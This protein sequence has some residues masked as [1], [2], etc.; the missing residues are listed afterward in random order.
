MNDRLHKQMESAASVAQS[1]WRNVVLPNLQPVSG[2]ARQQLEQP[3]QFRMHTVSGQFLSMKVGQQESDWAINFKKAIVV[4]FQTKSVNVLGNNQ[5]QQQQFNGIVAD[6]SQ[7]Q[8]NQ[9]AYWTT[10][11]EGLD[12]ICSVDYQINELSNGQAEQMQHYFSEDC[13][14][15]NNLKKF[16]VTKTR[17]VDSCTKRNVFGFYKPGFF[18]CPNSRAKAGSCEGQWTRTSMT[19]YYT[20]GQSYQQMQIQSVLNEGEL[21]QDLFGEK[22]ERFVTG[23]Q[24]RLVLISK[25]QINQHM[26]VA[27]SGVKNINSL[28]YG[29]EQ[30][31]SGIESIYS[32]I[33]EQMKSQRQH[34][35][36]SLLSIGHQQQQ[37]SYQEQRQQLSNGHIQKMIQEVVQTVEQ[38]VDQDLVQPQNRA[39]KEITMKALNLARALYLFEQEELNQV[40]NQLKS[41]YQSQPQQMTTMKNVFF[42]T[43]IM[44]GSQN[45]VLF[46]KQKVQS[47]QVETQQLMNFFVFMPHYIITPTELVLENIFDLIKSD[48]IMRE[49]QVIY[50]QA[51]LSFSALVQRACL[52]QT[53]ESSYPVELYGQFCSPKHQIVEAKWIP[54]LQQQVVAGQA[55]VEEKPEWLNLHL[56]ALS[57]LRHPAV[58]PTILNVLDMKQHQGQETQLPQALQMTR[59]IAVYALSNAGQAQPQTTIQ[60]LATILKNQG[61]RTEIRIAAFNSLLKM[62]PELYVLQSIAAM[63]WRESNKDVIDVINSGFFFLAHQ[64]DLPIFE[65]YGSSIQRKAALILPLLKWSR[66]LNQATLYLGDKLSMLDVSY[67]SIRSWRYDGTPS[68]IIPNNYYSRLTY[69][70]NRYQF[71]VSETFFKLN[72]YDNLIQQLTEVLIPGTQH[73]TKS[74]VGE[75]ILN[76]LNSEWK[77]VIKNLNIERRDQPQSSQGALFMNFFEDF[78]MFAS[79]QSTSSQMLREKLNSLIGGSPKASNMCGQ[80]NLNIQRFMDLSPAEYSIPSELGLPILIEVHMPVTLSLKGQI[81]VQCGQEKIVPDFTMDVRTLAIGQYVGYVGTVCPFTNEM[82]LTGVDQHTV[83]DLPFKTNVRFDHQQQ[84]VSVAASLSQEAQTNEFDVIHFHVRPYTVR[85]GLYSLMPF[86]QLPQTQFKK[87]QS[88]TQP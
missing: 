60:A 82:L 83:L 84:Q 56:V 86:S 8:Q 44:A 19:K 17:N 32:N 38:L 28:V 69:L 25:R 40:Y 31:K 51:I 46:L 47:Q 29:V 72:G 30:K 61:E 41:K 52:S 2:E 76:G 85:A 63:T 73:K 36:R 42:D 68:M 53:R 49:N 5:E 33:Q 7:Q 67:S 9:M 20:C 16:V 34:E 75:K 11:E 24:Q 14:E 64:R 22:T 10:T 70:L 78:P 77:Q 48:Y 62:N 27:S 58:I 1:N 21:E 65:Q 54:F 50:N 12:G 80:H 55:Q 18:R 71:V 87:I 88:P 15:N 74:Q 43:V 26:Q 66:N 81:N 3:T 45:C 13:R 39:S 35:P 57:N 23:S 59:Y 79:F 37:Q 4:L 6:D